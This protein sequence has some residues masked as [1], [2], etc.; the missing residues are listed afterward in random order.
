MMHDL[1]RRSFLA[2]T[3][4]AAGSLAL[5]APALALSSDAAETLVTSAVVDVNAIIASGASEAQMLREFQGVF[6]RYADTAYVAAFALGNDGRSATT[7]QKRNFSDAFGTYVARK[8]G[9]RFREFIG[10]EIIVQGARPE[11]NYMVVD[12][13]AVLQGESPFELEWHV[14]DRTGR[15]LFFNLIIEGVNMLLAERT[16]VG[17][18][19]DR[20]GGNIDALIED[21]RNA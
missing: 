12:S 16:E 7:T 3:G 13:T 2:L 1:P 15:P 18:L 8:Y 4:A 11:R 17:A 9:S 5:P 6:E 14:S 19:L 10:G 21:L 20:R